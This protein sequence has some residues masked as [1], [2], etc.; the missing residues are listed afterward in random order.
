M[1]FHIIIIIISHR[2]HRIV[3]SCVFSDSSVTTAYDEQ[4]KYFMTNILLLCI[5]NLQM[6]FYYY[7]SILSS[8]CR[9]IASSSCIKA[10]RATMTN[11]GICGYNR[12]VFC[13]VIC[14]TSAFIQVLIVLHVIHHTF[15]L[16]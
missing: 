9:I 4:H 8:V 7:Y 14:M 1:S 2:M 11:D 15:I 3:I 16:Q 5:K 10:F 6:Y 12:K 13:I